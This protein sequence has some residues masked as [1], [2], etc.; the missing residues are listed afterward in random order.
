MRAVSSRHLLHGTKNETDC[1]QKHRENSKLQREQLLQYWGSADMVR[2]ND[3]GSNSE[4]PAW[5]PFLLAMVNLT[6]YCA[7]FNLLFI[8]IYILAVENTNMS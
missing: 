6:S 7:H 1:T 8:Q 5:E 3:H 4:E 2:Q